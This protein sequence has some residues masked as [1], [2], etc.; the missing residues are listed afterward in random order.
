VSLRA[1]VIGSGQR[2]R[3][4]ALPAFLARS[5]AFELAGIYSRK[6]KQ[7]YAEDTT[8]ASVGAPLAVT[9]LAELDAARL[10]HA[11]LVFVCV[12]KGALP[13]VL[14]QLAG[15]VS[16]VPADAAPALLIDT[17]V[18]L[19]KH[20]AAARHFRAF[21][22]VWVAEDMST[23]PWLDVVTAARAE[24]GAPTRLTLDRSA[25]AYHGVA[26]AK[27][28]L[29]NAR[30][31]SARRRRLDAGRFER[32]LRFQGGTECRIL[33]P[34]DYA[35]GGLWLECEAGSLVDPGAG[36]VD[37]HG[38]ALRLLSRFDGERCLGFEA[39]ANGAD[40]AAF[41]SALAP[42]ETELLGCFDER[43][44]AARGVIAHMDA[45]KRVGF[46][47][48]LDRIAAEAPL[49]SLLDGLDDMWIDY[50]L[51]KTGRYLASPLT[52]AHSGLARRLVGLT[53]AAAL[54][55]KG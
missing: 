22:K 28:L 47:R 31:R 9:A 33:E 3:R 11:D 46:A 36:S 18:L 8:G 45:M 4:A 10:A 38:P 19:F 27:T 12:S 48:L 14:A 13:K 6:P 25:Y 32:R 23:L 41:T 30:V 34:R 44:R 20:M 17:P 21:Q 50:L 2:V 7:I 55:V 52:S 5:G 29:G 43:A 15:L 54:K 26:L 24:L 1:L 40:E 53:M 39:R 37:A 35:V 49:W 16:K 51:E 42:H